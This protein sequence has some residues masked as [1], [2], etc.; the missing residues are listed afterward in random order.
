[1]FSK[2]QLE[3][4]LFLDIE[5]AS[6]TQEFHELPERLRKHW[7]RRTELLNAKSEE[8]VSPEEM[9]PQKAAIYAEFGKVVCISCGYIRFE[10]ETPKFRVKSWYGPDEDSILREFKVMVD[11]FMAAPSRQL[12]A[13]NG[14]GFDLPF[15]GRR[16]LIRGIGVPDILR[17]I[18]MKKPWEIRLIDTMNFWKFGEFRSFA[19]L[20][21]L[22]AVLDIP[23]PK[24]DIDGSMVG[25]VF[26]E[27]K[28]YARIATYCEKDVVATAQVVLRFAGEPLIPD[29]GVQSV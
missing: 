16:Y 1:M 6:L 13:H 21:L 19:S 23:T 9:F 10:G 11:Q 15:L 25:K 12:C 24:D 5:T 8:D 17:D 4:I 18:Q 26:W 3:D 27:E 28:D 2:R 14:Q 29:N 7:E 20:D 22:T